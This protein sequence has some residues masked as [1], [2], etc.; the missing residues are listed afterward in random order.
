MGKVNSLPHD[1]AGEGG[2]ALQECFIAGGYQIISAP[3]TACASAMS[4]GAY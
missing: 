2:G 3:L 4:A 1:A